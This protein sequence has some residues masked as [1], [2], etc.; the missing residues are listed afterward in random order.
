MIP[1]NE[2]P[3]K[4]SIEGIPTDEIP[5]IHEQGSVFL[6]TAY[7]VKVFDGIPAELSDDD[8]TI[9][10][11]EVSAEEWRFDRYRVEATEAVKNLLKGEAFTFYD[12]S[13]VVDTQG[14]RE[15]E[16]PRL[17][18]ACSESYLKALVEA[19]ARTESAVFI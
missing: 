4:A 13:L 14:V 19:K 3:E 11:R 12:L 15:Q 17:I 1:L 8:R 7:R 2:L 5:S 16:S 6:V 18:F 9:T 10:F